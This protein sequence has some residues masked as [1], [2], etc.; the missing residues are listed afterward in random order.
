[1]DLQQIEFGKLNDGRQVD[2]FILC[3]NHGITAQITNYGGILVALQMPDNKGEIDNVCLGFD[4]LQRYLQGHPY[5]GCTVGRYANRIGQGAFTISGHHYRLACNEN[6]VS[7]LHGGVSGFDKKLWQAEPFLSQKQAGVK[8]TYKSPDGEEGYPG[9]L[10]T[11]V[12]YALNEKDELR[13]D[14]TAETDWTT[15]VNLTNHAYWNFSG[16]GR[17]LILDH[18]LVLNCPSYL[19]VDEHLLPTGEIR[20]VFNTPFDFTFAKKI[21]RDID[22]VN[23]YDHCFIIARPHQDLVQA[24]VVWDP[25]SG[26][27]M[28]VWTTKPG[29]QLYTGNFLDGLVGAGGMAYHRQSALCLETQYYPDA[30]HHDH[31]PSC[32]LYPGQTYHHSTVHKFFVKK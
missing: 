24:A 2:Q 31:F 17:G 10:E 12:I 27:G 21:G 18:K 20:S 22:L 4:D 30:V 11:T 3:N 9:N 7:H 5:M 25:G 14:Y 13:I 16:A 19:P 15:P 6:G 28:E 32:W 29:I 23:G 1:M 8:L 26:R